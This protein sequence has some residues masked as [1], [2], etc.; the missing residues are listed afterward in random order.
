M[1]YYHIELMPFSTRLCTIIIPWGK[2]KYQH[3]QMC[4]CN[5]PDIFQEHMFELFSDLEYVQVYINDLLVMSCS[6]FEEHLEWFEKVLLQLSEVGLNI[7]ANKLHFAKVEIEYL[8]YWITQ[9]G[10]QPLPKKVE[11]LQNIAPPKSKKQL[12]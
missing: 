12:Q 6:T 8:G 11:A 3:L 7:N 2:Y 5:S 1:G 4:L 9:D 10:I